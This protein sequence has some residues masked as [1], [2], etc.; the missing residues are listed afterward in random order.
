MANHKDI[1]TSSNNLTG[2]VD[3]NNAERL[4]SYDLLG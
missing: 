1:D 4:P 3:Q 2:R